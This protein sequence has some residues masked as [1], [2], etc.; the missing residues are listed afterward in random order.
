MS[1]TSEDPSIFIRSMATRGSLGG[2]SKATLD[3]IQILDAAG[4]DLI[5]VETVGVGQAEVDIVRTADTVLVVLVPGMG[6]S[7]QIIKAGILEIADLFVINKADRDG[8]DML[9]KDLRIL[10]SL[11]ETGADRWEPLIARTI[12]TSGT[13]ASEVVD[14]VQRHSEW[15]RSSALGKKKRLEILEHNI[16]QLLTE[17]TLERSLSEKK[18]LLKEL[19]EA[20][21]ERKIDPYSAVDRLLADK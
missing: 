9:H 10:L 20:C 11:A 21:Y 12:A 4:F 5:L 14:G 7:V 15:V 13:G 6:D 17:I 19:V 8:A 16:L 18:P 1:H 3:T 2:L